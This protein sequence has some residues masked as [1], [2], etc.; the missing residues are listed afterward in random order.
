V[1][2]EQDRYDAF[3]YPGYSYPKTHPDR[4]AVMAILHGLSP[5]PIER[6]RV[7]EVACGDGANIIPMAYAIPAGE[8]V[9]FDLAMLP[10]ERAQ[11]RIREL[12]L[13]NIRIFQ[14]DLLTLEG[15][16]GGFDYIIA[17]GFYSWVPV[18]VRDRFFALCSRVLAPNGVVFVSYN[19]LPGSYLRLMLRDMM[20]FRTQGIDNPEQT[21]TAGQEFARTIAAARPEGDFQREL[22]EEQLRRLESH[23]AASTYH[24]ELNPEYG[25]L[26]FTD[27][28]EHARSHGLEY[29]AD[30]ELPPP[31]DPCYRADLQQSIENV[32]GG[33]IIRAEQALDFI[34]MRSYRE[35][36]LCRASQPIRRDYFPESF[37]NLLLASQRPGETPSS[38]IF[39]LPGGTTMETS[40][41]AVIW[42]LEIL[43]EAWPRAIS[44]RELMP[45]FAELGLS[46]DP[47]GTLLLVRLA[48]S[49]MIELRSWNPLLPDSIS[50]RPRVSA[51]TRQEAY[52][53]GR[54]ATT[55]LHL[56]V[57]FED[58]KIQR[59]LLLLD[60]TRDRADLLHAMQSEFPDTPAAEIERHLE[61]S[62]RLFYRAGALEA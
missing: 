32:S 46:L 1:P 55:L 62:L 42:L 3:A 23:A 48:V 36:L 45:R 39:E 8:F 30:A 29:L 52:H 25:P 47:A 16:L 59:L 9:G 51:C 14:G 49:K 26:Y 31:P 37:F 56:T 7:L 54:P 19:T 40:H 18:Q 43:G 22:I 57:K 60:G 34:R 41:P 4:L 15:D 10:V 35:T 20:L 33:D 50:A 12:S 11:A 58:A 28:I 13:G 44:F 27:F 6:C 2:P 5:A 21:V 61:P 17:H 24:D 53:L 38:R